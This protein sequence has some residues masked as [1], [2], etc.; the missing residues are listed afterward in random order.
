MILSGGVGGAGQHAVEI[1]RQDLDEVRLPGGQTGLGGG[2]IGGDRLNGEVRADEAANAFL[3]DPRQAARRQHNSG[4][5]DRRTVDIVRA[6]ED[7]HQQRA[8][9][10]AED[11]QRLAADLMNLFE[12]IG[13]HTDKV[14][15]PYR[16]GDDPLAGARA[17]GCER[18]VIDHAASCFCSSC[19]I[20]LIKTSS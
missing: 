11:Q 12:K 1:G 9:D 19:C 6:E 18:G 7:Q 10:Q 16:D 8:D 17:F 3:A 4:A 13:P 2:A 20:I 15:A 14:A 5:D